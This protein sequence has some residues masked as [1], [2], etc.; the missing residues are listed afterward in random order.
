M[1]R[2]WL[3]W[4]FVIGSC[5]MT[6]AAERAV[7][8]AAEDA[9]VEAL[10]TMRRAGVSEGRIAVL[11]L[12]DDQKNVTPVF[13]AELGRYPGLFEIYVRDD[14]EWN[15]LLSEIEFSDRRSDVMDPATLQKFGA[16]K[17]VDALLYG[18]VREASV[19][20][21]GNG[22]VRLAL[23]LSEVETGRRLWSGNVTGQY[24]LRQAPTG[25]RL[26]A[27]VDAARKAA[28]LLAEQ[29]A[30]LGRAD[31]YALPVF[32]G[33]VDYTDFVRSEL[34][35][36]SDGSMRM[37]ADSGREA[38]GRMV[39]NLV[40]E[41]QSGGHAAGLADT[42]GQMELFGH[43][44]GARRLLLHARFG[45]PEEHPELHM[46]SIGLNL[47]LVDIGSGQLVWGTTVE[48]RSIDAVGFLPLVEH[49]WKWVLGILAGLIVLA[50]LIKNMRRVR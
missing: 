26:K 39:V 45:E 43:S 7:D 20:Y 8:Y 36:A 22:T 44:G 11:P 46:T 42:L 34:L 18:S 3:V 1:F 21:A 49:Y 29:S 23:T 28:A 41:L 5:C 25:P 27:A 12:T 48:G 15:K 13:K 24:V 32:S 9:A 17:G 4:S 19:D 33:S 16:I 14:S 2:K 37:L 10:K 6:N 50:V 30:S 38:G 47:Q 40:R 35:G 31:V